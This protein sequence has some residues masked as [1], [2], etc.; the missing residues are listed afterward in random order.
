M[1]VAAP[2]AAMHLVIAVDTLVEGVHFSFAVAPEAIGHK[3]LAVN[4]SD[5]AA[6]G[7][8]PR[9]ARVVVRYAPARGGWLATLRHGLEQ[10]ANHHGVMVS[11]FETLDDPATPAAVTVQIDGRVPAGR[12]LRRD[13]ALPGHDLWVSGEPGLAGLALA[14]HAGVAAPIAAVAS[15]RLDRPQPRV[16]LGQLLRHRASAAIAVSAR[17]GPH[18]GHA[19]RARGVAIEITTA[20]LPLESL[21]AAGLQPASAA[22]L[23]LGAGDDYEL[24]FCAPRR[25]R[26]ALAALAPRAGCALTRI[27]RVL[28]GHGVHLLD[29]TGSAVPAVPGYRHFATASDT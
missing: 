10:L 11:A 2:A 16:A 12:A 5:L 28:R 23:A 19:A 17:L 3:A 18:A 13:G 15:Q 6:M 25:E 8:E 21:L 29:A 14:P 1:G 9:A 20:D 27:G 4:L 7:A 24:C 26:V 22:R